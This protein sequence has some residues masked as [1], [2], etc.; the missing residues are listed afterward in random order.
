MECVQSAK[1]RGR[2]VCAWAR[3][4]RFRPG[5]LIIGA[6]KAGTTSLFRYLGEHSRVKPPRTKESRFFDQ[7][8]GRGLDWYVSQCPHRWKVSRAEMTVDASPASLFH[9][10]APGRAAATLPEAKI[11]VLL[12]NPVDRAYSQ[13]Q[14][15]ARR[16]RVTGSFEEELERE[17]ELLGGEIDRGAY[18]GSYLARGRYAEQLER[19][20]D[21]YGAERMIVLQSERFFA[22]TQEE[23]DRVLDFL[24]LE[25]E[26]VRVTTAHNTGGTYAPVAGATRR[27]L[28]EAFGGWNV[29]LAELLS[30]HGLD[31][32]LSIGAGG[33]WGGREAS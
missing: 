4:G 18:T 6:Q 3:A 15:N 33:E 25:R 8:W 9:P 10:R 2:G 21:T 28:E 14:H 1:G 22:R 23:V 32:G 13:Y 27:R 16:G 12:R 19:W 11:I 30:R 5:A 26:P 29:R 31:M 20:I 7:H 17:G 24:G